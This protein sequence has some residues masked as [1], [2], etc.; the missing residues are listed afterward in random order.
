MGTKQ[1]AILAVVAVV[2]LVLVYYFFVAGKKWTVATTTNVEP[3]LRETDRQP[4]STKTGVAN[5]KACEKVCANTGKC[6]AYSFSYTGPTRGACHVWSPEQV[7]TR[8]RDGIP[9]T[10][11]ISRW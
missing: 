9:N 4:I 1:K 6:G 5:A 7:D 10:T 2:V 8:D 11:T 3:P